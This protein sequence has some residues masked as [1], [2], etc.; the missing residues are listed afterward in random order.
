[1]C[2][3]TDT[4]PVG[5]HPCELRVAS[6]RGDVVDRDGARFDAR[7]HGCL[8]R[9]DGDRAALRRSRPLDAPGSSPLDA[10]EPTFD[11]PP[12]HER[13]PYR[14]QRQRHRASGR[15]KRPPSENESGVMFTTPTTAGRGKAWFSGGPT[16]Q[17]YPTSGLIDLHSHI[18]PGLD[19]GSRTVE[20][21]RA[22]ARRA[23]DDGV[24]AIAATP[25]GTGFQPVSSA[26]EHGLETGATVSDVVSDTRSEADRR[27]FFC[28]SGAASSVVAAAGEAER[29]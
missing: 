2:I 9:V 17:P 16:A 23:A 20:D 3:G 4:R 14:S 11:S 26:R 21:A 1:M 13:R 7:R 8:R 18:L 22:L 12:V 5:D 25:R 6:E 10:L 24:T 29:A 19:D 15:R 28:P 27:P